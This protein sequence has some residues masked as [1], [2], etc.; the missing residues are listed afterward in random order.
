MNLEDLI[1][2]HQLK[3]NKSKYKRPPNLQIHNMELTHLWNSNA[4]D[5]WEGALKK[6]WE[7][8]KSEN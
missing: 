8:V 1:R 5:E 2:E 3:R 7:F 4:E 6:Y